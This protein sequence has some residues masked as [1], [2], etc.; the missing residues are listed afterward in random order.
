MFGALF[1][2]LPAGAPTGAEVTPEAPQGVSHG[3]HSR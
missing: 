1:R 3:P 2:K